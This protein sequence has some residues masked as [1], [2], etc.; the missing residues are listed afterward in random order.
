MTGTEDCKLISPARLSN[1]K[2]TGQGQVGGQAIPI[3]AIA[4]LPEWRYET[5]GM[6]NDC[7]ITASIRT[8]CCPSV[9]YACRFSCTVHSDRPHWSERCASRWSDRR[10][11]GDYRTDPLSHRHKPTIIGCVQSIGGKSSLVDEKDKRTY[12]LTGD[13]LDLKAGQRMKLK[14]K[15]IKARDGDSTF[16]VKRV[17]HD[18]GGCNQ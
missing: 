2:E 9:R 18:Y 17:D 15:K 3:L 7:E 5:W 12:A 14:G 8:N 16:L 1:R 6:T 11:H 13:H 10:S 4:R